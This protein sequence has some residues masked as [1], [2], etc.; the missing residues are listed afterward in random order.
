VISAEPPWPSRDDELPMPGFLGENPAG[1]LA[2]RPFM[3]WA[4]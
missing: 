3:A 4:S 2:R 1:G